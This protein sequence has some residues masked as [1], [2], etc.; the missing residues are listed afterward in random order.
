M[1]TKDD[2]D[3][4]GA[5][6]AASPAIQYAVPDKPVTGT[7]E[8]IM[9]SFE[10]QGADTSG[11]KQALEEK[12]VARVKQQYEDSI[13]EVEANVAA[14]IEDQKKQMLG[15]GT[16]FR[17]LGKNVYNGL[18][19]L[20]DAAED[21]AAEH[22]IGKGDLITSSM[23]WQD[24][25]GADAKAA[26]GAPGKVA[27]AVTQFAM[28]LLA[29]MSTGGGVGA[30]LAFDAV[31]GVLAV[32]PKQQRVSDH[33]KGTVFEQ[34]PIV[35]D[36]IEGLSSKPDDSELMSRF[37]NAA[38]GVGIGAGLAGLMWTAAR[39]YSKA[40]G[41]TAAV[42]DEAK[43]PAD[44]G[45]LVIG[46]GDKPTTVHEEP[47]A[48]IEPVVPEPV[49]SPTVSAEGAVELDMKSES[50]LDKFY[51]WAKSV[52]G[53]RLR[54]PLSNRELMDA[55]KEMQNDPEIWE[56]IAT[57]TP[58][59]GVLTDKETMVF[60]YIMQQSD[61]QMMSTIKGLQTAP[62]TDDAALVG[63][64]E[65]F[66]NYTRL[67]DIR[68]GA[69]SAKGATL[70]AEQLIQKLARV[71]DKDALA[72]MGAEGRA[73]LT[74]GIMESYGGREAI[75]AT[76]EKLKLIERLSSVADMPDKAFLSRM[77]KLTKWERMD[78]AVTRVAL[79]GMLSSPSTSIKAL[80][81]NVGTTGKTAL[82]KYVSVGV[83]KL[84]GTTGANTISDANAQVEGMFQGMIESIRPSINVLKTGEVP[85][86]VRMDLVDALKDA[87]PTMEEQAG[88][89][90]GAF[91]DT[92]GMIVH[93]AEKVSDNAVT[94]IPV[95]V[96]MSVDSY[97]QHVNIR[98]QVLSEASRAARKAG[99][100]GKA[101]A[102]FIEKFRLNP[103]DAVYEAAVKTA[104]T[105][106]MAKDLSGWAAK[107]DDLVEGAAYIPTR[108]VL[109]PFIKTNLNLVEYAATN[110][111]LGV[112]APSFQSAMRQGGRARDEAM[113]KV[114][115]GSTAT[116]LIAYAAYK[117]LV[118]GKSSENLQVN[119]ALRDNKTVAPETSLKFG[120]TWVS[121]KGVE[122]IATIMNGVSLLSK[123]AGYL[124]E[125]EYGDMT[126]SFVAALMEV[127]TPEQLLDT[128]SG[129]VGAA[130]GSK[131]G[132]SW[133]ESLPQ[134]YVP[135]GAAMTD[136]RQT[137]DPVM[138]STKS[139]EGKGKWG[140]LGNMV[141][142]MQLRVQNMV[143]YYSKDL[144]PQTNIWG[145]VLELPDGL[146]PDAL[147]MFA[148]TTN[149]G[150]ML[151]HSLEAMD[152][153]YEHTKGTLAGLTKF[154]VSM[155]TDRV[156]NAAGGPQFKLT[157][158]E[159]QAYKMMA[160]GINPENGETIGKET[161][162]DAATRIVKQYGA[163]KMRPQDFDQKTYFKMVA[164]LSAEFKSRR[165]MADKL[166]VTFGDVGRRMKDEAREYYRLA[167]GGS[168]G[169]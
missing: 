55:A 10:R 54:A 21:F 26:M 153:Y 126:T 61:S 73:K 155:P 151:K 4:M 119:L 8:Q 120:D 156:A 165:D 162:K 40:A 41:R 100:E 76:Q 95:R 46:G 88:K 136:I 169:R 87:V 167:P 146:G 68:T 90:L 28:S 31:Y 11:M 102:D 163:D 51:N 131:E 16:A 33:L 64:M 75:L 80:V 71:G 150:G 158:L 14:G 13:K 152:D 145:E 111:P 84:M 141:D 23:K 35:S 135:F 154:E 98:G 105:N 91:A 27:H 107:L 62:S 138:R 161:L 45:P 129:I 69:A 125:A 164:A 147:S 148:S 12:K 168:N 109:V 1:L 49:P 18:I 44:G 124:S 32:D 166:I 3:N 78:R 30:G 47:A 117:G 116:G 113:A 139:D 22:G 48:P 160:A 157:P 2:I 17:D 97:W 65:K 93:A 143:P 66:E 6:R 25:D 38:E 58:E 81:A 53:D 42:V 149:E 43:P 29:G 104:G 70:K 127:M 92:T 83:G 94:Q 63:F 5:A 77:E 121:M 74:A 132:K 108:R 24:T 15:V 37:K 140:A 106:T 112:F 144:P 60:K 133:V 89:S 39:T 114:I 130:E 50:M 56:K 159:H 72:M 82:D 59:N 115:S 34:V 118:T 101:A 134:R 85:Q 122:P 128:A 52:P 99:L 123:S 36:I 137:V 79:N 110:S 57:N 96:L 142:T 7:Y 19:D 67:L 9:A 86:T 103:P 20:S